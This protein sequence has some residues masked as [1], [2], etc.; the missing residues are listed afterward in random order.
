MIPLPPAVQTPGLADH[1]LIAVMVL[2][3]FVEAWWYWPRVL[4]AL[5]NRVPGARMRAY[6]N[7]IVYEWALVAA[8]VAIW[9]AQHRAWPA[10]HAGAGLLLPTVVGAALLGAYL[11]IVLVK[12]R[13][14]IASPERL[15]RFAVRQTNVDPLSPRTTE[16]QRLFKVLAVTAGFCEEFLFRGF[17]LWYFAKLAGPVAGF[18]LAA[19]MFG[20]G[21]LYLGRMHVVR[22]TIVG[23][24]FG[25]LVV[26]TGSLWVA[27][28]LHVAMDLIGGEVGGRAFRAADQR[29]GVAS[30][31]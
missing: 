4:R 22:T 14:L 25:L 2:A 31:A 16:E 8:V 11:T 5:A 9:I 24:V 7:V 1:M 12:I 28:A 19:L 10:L 15:A 21:H 6:R 26:G 30:P 17:A 29:A 23:A 20:I 13:A 27:I 18:A 3:S